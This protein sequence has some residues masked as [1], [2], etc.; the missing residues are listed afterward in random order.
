MHQ[1][2]LSVHAGRTIPRE[3]A[4]AHVPPLDFST[5]YRIHDAVAAEASL[6][7]M[8]QGAPPSGNAVYAR[9]HNPTV[10]GFEA[11]LARLEGADTAV[12]FASGMAAITAVVLAV[13]DAGDEV[14]A[15]RP[16]YGGTD[17]LLTE[18]LLG[19][20]VVWVDA[21]HVGD[22]VG[23]DTALVFLETPANPTLQ[24]VEIRSVVEQA[25]SVPVAVDSTFA[26]PILQNPLAQG[27]T[28][29]VH[30]ATKF[31][32]G[33]GDAL[34]G[35]VATS[36]RRARRLRQVR[37][38]TGAVLGPVPA[39]LLHRG[40]QTLP[41]RVRAQEATALDVVAALR[42]DPRVSRVYYP[43]LVAGQMRGT[44][45]LVSFELP[46]GQD[47]ADTV[48]ASLKLVT[49]AVSLG[50]VD[51]LIQR[52]AALTHRVV[53]ADARS[54]GGIPDGLLRLS[55][56]LEAASDLLEDLDQALDATGSGP[57]SRGPTAC[58]HHLPLPGRLAEIGPVPTISSGRKRRQ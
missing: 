25:G 29:A 45:S 23:P 49:P 40:L 55:V 38:A 14:V 43:R 15:V 39:W 42:A 5:T 7:A 22:A 50:S 26:T 28:F 19:T 12:A 27:A 51:T 10:A 17:H 4:A 36:E 31:I 11:A 34:G 44:G 58:I 46:G 37:I 54:A 53:D 56:G 20:R 9:L 3:A 35:V 52:P 8:V 13:R 47:A 24:T 48:M 6:D 16:L 32:G 2:T 1:R 30:S 57:A 33:H 21:E 41:V 18:G